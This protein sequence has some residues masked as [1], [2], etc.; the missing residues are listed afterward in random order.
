MSAAADTWTLKEIDDALG[1]VKGS[2]FR[3]FK[4]LGDALVENRDYRHLSAMEHAAAIQALKDAGRLYPSSRNALLFLE[5]GRAAILAWLGRHADDPLQRKAEA[6]VA[7]HR[8]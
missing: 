1:M 4:R 2:A 8:H 6:V 3:A 5:P 7:R